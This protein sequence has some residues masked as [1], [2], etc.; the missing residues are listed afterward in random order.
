MGAA[1]LVGAGGFIGAVG[2]YL[3]GL[4]PCGGDF[5]LMTFLVNFLGAVA[6][7]AVAEAASGPAAL[8]AEAALFLKTG[9]C[10]GFTTF[11]R[12]RS[13]R[14]RFWRREGRFGRAVRGRQRGRVRARRGG[15]AV[16]LARGVSAMSASA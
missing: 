10:G 7:G 14:S 1:L 8:P 12:S 13:R 5:P 11:S 16:R 6:I 4:V 15:G 2:R 9:V 3:L